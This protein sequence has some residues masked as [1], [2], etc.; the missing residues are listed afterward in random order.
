MLFGLQ[1]LE[2]SNE[3]LAD[4]E[5]T[6]RYASATY[7]G[8]CGIATEQ[9]QQA[10][11]SEQQAH[12]LAQQT[13]ETRKGRVRNTN[14][15]STSRHPAARVPA[16]VPMPHTQRVWAP[17]LVRPAPQLPLPARCSCLLRTRVRAG[18]P[19]W[20]WCPACLPA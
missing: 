17:R 18:A 16:L 2:M 15:T 3:S 11:D 20:L 19:L 5:R 7:S 10:K 8:N 9:G 6:A 1:G 13:H 4:S 12:F 14:I